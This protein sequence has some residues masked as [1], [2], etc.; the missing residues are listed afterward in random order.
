MKKTASRSVGRIVEDVIISAKKELM[1]ATPKISPEYV[2]MILEKAEEVKVKVVTSDIKALE[3]L[4]EPS[5]E[6]SKLPLTIAGTSAVLLL[7]GIT[8]KIPIFVL[9]SLPLFIFSIV[10]GSAV[11]ETVRRSNVEARYLE[12]LEESIYVNEERGVRGPPLRPL[13]LWEEF[14]EAEVYEGHEVQHLR[15]KFERLWN[16]A[17]AF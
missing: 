12:D 16:K 10:Y 15:E 6:G 4:V 13:E 5:E 2:E 1:I 7:M 17:K 9:A 3:R 11:V 14:R 8:F